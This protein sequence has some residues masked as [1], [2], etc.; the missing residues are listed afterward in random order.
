MLQL[1]TRFDIIAFRDAFG[2]SSNIYDR[3]F[4]KISQHTSLPLIIFAKKLHSR[5]LKGS[6]M[7]FWMHLFICSKEN[8]S[9]WISF[10]VKL[11]YKILVEYLK[12]W[13]GANAFLYNFFLFIYFCVFLFLYFYINTEWVKKSLVMIFIGDNFRH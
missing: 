9:C 2:T 4:C 6:W 13:L 3:V 1:F 5:Y 10:C 7:C 12:W 11:S 8:I